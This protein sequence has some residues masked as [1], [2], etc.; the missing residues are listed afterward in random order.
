[1]TNSESASGESPLNGNLRG[2]SFNYFAWLGPIVTFVSA[3]CYFAY[4][5]RFPDLWDF[6]WVNL[7]LVGAGAI[8]SI[9]GVNR[10]FRVPGVVEVTQRGGRNERS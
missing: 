4:F 3:I 10:A 2:L 1:M 5:V 9:V 8:L 7:P 6:P